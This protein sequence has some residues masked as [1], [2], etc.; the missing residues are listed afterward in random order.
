MSE[1]Q[2]KANNI[3]IEDKFFF[4]EIIGKVFGDSVNL[5]LKHAFSISENRWEL[6]FISCDFQSILKSF[7]KHKN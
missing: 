1:D 7:I 3:A 2:Q 5:M 6:K 4:Q